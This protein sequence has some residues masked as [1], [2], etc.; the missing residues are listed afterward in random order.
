[1]DLEPALP[2]QSGQQYFDGLP[3]SFQ[4]CSPD[5]W[6]RN[7]IDKRRRAIRRQ[8]PR[9]LPSATAVDYLIAGSDLTRQGDLRFAAA[10]GGPF[11]DPGH[12]VPKLVSLPRLLAAADQVSRDVDD[13]AAVKDLL[14]AGSGSLGGARPKASALTVVGDVHTAVRRWRHAADRNGIDKAEQDRFADA[15]DGQLAALGA[16][17][18]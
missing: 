18:R 8:A 11:L 1:M 4:D 16:L 15:L 5:R 2:R 17:T 12:A 3:G 10:D 13:Y 7:L 14:D 6:G 9:R